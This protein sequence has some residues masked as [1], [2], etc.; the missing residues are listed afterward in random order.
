MARC[1]VYSTVWYNFSFFF[2]AILIVVRVSD[3]R[4]RKVIFVP[5][6]SYTLI[7]VVF[8]HSVS[9]K[10][11]GRWNFQWAN[12]S[13]TEECIFFFVSSPFSLANKKK[14]LLVGAVCRGGLKELE[15]FFN[16]Y[17]IWLSLPILI[18][19]DDCMSCNVRIQFTDG[20]CSSVL[21]M[22]KKI[23]TKNG[24][25]NEHSSRHIRFSKPA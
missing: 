3:H 23:Y 25:R 21:A 2:F 10:W 8:T 24:I 16:Y 14:C 6:L 12:G 11:N 18:S 5:C 22:R 19:V 13:T 1:S 17:F 7:Y 20:Y 9:R 15:K 4:R